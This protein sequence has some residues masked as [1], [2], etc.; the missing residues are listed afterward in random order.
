MP[1]GPRGRDVDQHWIAPMRRPRPDDVGR[2]P[3]MQRVGEGTAI[4]AH[5]R[6]HPPAPVVLDS[7]ASLATMPEISVASLTQV[8][9]KAAAR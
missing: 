2:R 1:S 9:G 7:V 6:E 8:S 4:V 3:D 5:G